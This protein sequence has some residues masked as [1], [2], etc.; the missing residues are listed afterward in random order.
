MNDIRRTF[1]D[2][3]EVSRSVLA[4]PQIAERWEE[5]SALAEFSIRGLAGHLFRGTG[6]VLAYLD[7]EEPT[8]TTP[9]SAAVYYSLAVDESDI[10]SDLHRAVREKGEAEAAEGHARLLERFDEAFEEL[11]ARLEKEPTGR[12]VRVF[13]D[14]VLSLDDYL[15]TRLVELTIHI[16]DLAVS[17]G[18]DTPALPP[19]ATELSIQTLVDV[20]R[21]RHGDIAVLRGLGRRER[22]PIEALRVL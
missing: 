4:S 20:A 6:S 15:I 11:Q 2:T 21:L 19:H 13:K 10:D 3:A 8:E 9:A 16:D 5:P 14:I 12:L 18:L 1:L 17:V 22:D 7:R